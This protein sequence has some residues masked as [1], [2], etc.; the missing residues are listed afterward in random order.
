MIDDK[1]E[2]RPS[3]WRENPGYWARFGG[4]WYPNHS[5]RGGWLSEV[6]RRVIR[7]DESPSIEIIEQFQNLPRICD[8]RLRE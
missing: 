5:P 7:S 8:I 3:Y 6:A 4:E 1:R 2:Y